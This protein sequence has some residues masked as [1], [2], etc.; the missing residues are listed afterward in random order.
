MLQRGY[1]APQDI[2]Y[3][4]L[5]HRARGGAEGPLPER[6]NPNQQHR[7]HNP[8]GLCEKNDGDRTH[9]YRPQAD[10]SP[11]ELKPAGSY[12]ESREE[13]AEPGGSQEYPSHVGAT[14][15][16]LGGEYG[17]QEQDR[18]QDCVG[19]EAQHY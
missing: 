14:V 15:Q 9:G 1:P 12:G 16:H 8:A 7:R 13:P 19:D 10:E 18:V 3:Q 2:G 11:P 5:D 6:H 4:E 17:Q